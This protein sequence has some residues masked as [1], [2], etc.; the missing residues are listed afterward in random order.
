MLI[1]ACWRILASSRIP[2]YDLGRQ[3]RHFRGGSVTEVLC[4][5]SEMIIIVGIIGDQVGQLGESGEY[6]MGRRVSGWVRMNN[7]TSLNDTLPR[8]TGTYRIHGGLQTE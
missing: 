2:R 4:G 5:F 1:C 7:L 6:W 8:F 3:T